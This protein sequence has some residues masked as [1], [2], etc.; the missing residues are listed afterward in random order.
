MDYQSIRSSLRDLENRLSK[1]R[2][3]VKVA[4]PK[5]GHVSSKDLLALAEYSKRDLY[6]AFAL[7]IVYG[8][9]QGL[10]AAKG[11]EMKK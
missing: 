4:D 9:A 10:R 2:Q 1:I 6:S 8:Q 3:S 7:A 11:E 5:I